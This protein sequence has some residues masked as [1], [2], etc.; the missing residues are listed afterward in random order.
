VT[1]EE[2]SACGGTLGEED[3]GLVDAHSVEMALQ[4]TA[5]STGPRSQQLP[6]RGVGTIRKFPEVYVGWV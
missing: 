3:L 4:E 1:E 5:A 2:L 6:A